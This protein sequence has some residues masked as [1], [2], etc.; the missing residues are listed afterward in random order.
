MATWVGWYY[1]TKPFWML[2]QRDDGNGSGGNQNYT[3]FKK[4]ISLFE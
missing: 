1:T 4:N 2:L 3:V